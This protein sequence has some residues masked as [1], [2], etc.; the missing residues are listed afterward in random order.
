MVDVLEKPARPVNKSV[1]KEAEDAELAGRRSFMDV[2]R[3]HEV[4]RCE[5]RGCRGF[6]VR[7]RGGR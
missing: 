6:G 3:G 4:S 2:V 7:W 5:R 1:K